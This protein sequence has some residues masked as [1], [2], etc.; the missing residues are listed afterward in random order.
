MKCKIYG[1]NYFKQK[2]TKLGTSAEVVLKKYQVPGTVPVENPPKVNCT[3]P[4]RAIPCSG[5]APYGTGMY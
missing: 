1:L 2:E 4:Y 5:K 3:E